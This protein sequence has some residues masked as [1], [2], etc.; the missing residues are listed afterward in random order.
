MRLLH[1][2]SL[3]L[4]DFPNHE[5]ISYAILSHTW[6]EEEVLFEDIN[7][8][9]ARTMP[10]HIKQK[11]GYKKIKACCAQAASDG[12]DAVWIDTCCI[13]K[14]S[15]AELSEAINSMYR[16]YQDCTVCYVYLADVSSDDSI[17]VRNQRFR[18]SRWFTRGWT[19]QELIAPLN[20]EF[21]GDQWYS[22]G[23]ACSLGTKVSLR[24]IISEI[25]QV[26]ERC[27]ASSTMG[28]WGF[29]IAQRMSWAANRETTR[30]ED[31]AYSLLGLFNINMPLLYGEGTRAFVRLQEEIL[32]TSDDETLFAW[33][34]ASP[35]KGFNGLEQ[36]LLAMSPDSFAASS[37]I[38]SRL[39]NPR[40]ITSTVT[41]KG[42][43]LEVM[44]SEPRLWG[45]EPPTAS[46]S[47]GQV[48]IALLNCVEERTDGTAA[49]MVG[50]FMA[51]L[52]ALG[53][54]LTKDQFV[55]I[56]T[57]RLV[58]L[59]PKF[60]ESSGSQRITI[61][62]RLAQCYDP[63]AAALH[64]WK[65]QHE[66]NAQ[67][68][69][70]I[71]RESPSEF[72]LGALWPRNTWYTDFSNNLC[73]GPSTESIVPGLDTFR[74]AGLL[75]G[76]KNGV[77]ALLVLCRL[78]NGPPRVQVCRCPRGAI[79]GDNEEDY[80]YLKNIPTD[81]DRAICRWSPWREVSASLRRER[82]LGKSVYAL[83][84]SVNVT[85]KMEVDEGVRDLSRVST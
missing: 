61:F 3:E 37:K 78:G 30:I 33:K 54:N 75:F 81:S 36:G 10:S 7:G 6:A 62:A 8:F 15:S 77:G 45:V 56:D 52:G 22:K 5:G 63:V 59:N 39:L 13:D 55:R 46:L 18:E 17:E 76:E 34:S 41:N 11:Q 14:R 73:V 35:G 40:S 79:I 65:T 58:Y 42:L 68:W 28:P 44:L 43:R 25:T 70:V 26:P 23:Q 84:I 82:F 64:V 4:R 32:K 29:S 80:N 47:E 27:L 31:R 71:L 60:N 16:W 66:M 21:Y 51:T 1:S 67:H 49:E 2:E 50:I 20:L 53:K 83:R 24:H 48:Y 57:G 72:R 85:G 38:T 69:M 74:T 19:L 12:F 9:N